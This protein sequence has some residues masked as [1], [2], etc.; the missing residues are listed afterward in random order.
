M[1]SVAQFGD[2]PTA[3]LTRE[4]L[5]ARLTALGIE[6]RTVDHVAVFTVAESAAVEAELSAKIPGTA[7]KNLFLKDAKDK[8]YLLVAEA[9]AAIDLK[10]LPQFIGSGRL[11]FGKPELLKRVLGVEPGSVTAFAIANAAPETITLLLDKTLAAASHVNCH[12]MTN[13]ATTNI[14]VR[15]LLAFFRKHGHAPQIVDLSALQ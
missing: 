6:T 1:T 2:V 11:S 7:T 15:D 5:L 9:H 14:A 12:P 10:R 3:H 13:T 4:T 8:L